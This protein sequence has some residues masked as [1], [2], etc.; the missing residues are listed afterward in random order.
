MTADFQEIFRSIPRPA[1]QAILNPL[2]R[3]IYAVEWSDSLKLL[4]VE[5]EALLS[6][7]SFRA[8]AARIHVMEAYRD[9]ILPSAALLRQHQQL[10]QRARTIK[11]L[12]SESMQTLRQMTRDFG[13]SAGG[14][15]TLPGA[16]FAIHGEKRTWAALQ[17]QMEIEQ[18][19]DPFDMKG[20]NHQLEPLMANQ[21][22]LLSD[23]SLNQWRCLSAEYRA[24]DD[25]VAAVQLERFLRL[26]EEAIRQ[27]AP[28]AYEA[29]RARFLQEHSV[30]I[31]ATQPLMEAESDQELRRVMNAS[32]DIMVRDVGFMAMYE[33]IQRATRADIPD[34]ARRAEALFHLLLDTYTSGDAIAWQRFRQF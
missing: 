15:S 21:A 3:Y 10:L 22:L 34:A 1:T 32:R 30:C 18:A 19:K 13:A 26:L 9:D 7:N 8:L 14:Y 29:Y 28:V 33:I 23:A 11:P 25:V 5:H 27:G 31:A 2:H 20:L 17:T 16:G 12:T 6:D 24:V 4:L